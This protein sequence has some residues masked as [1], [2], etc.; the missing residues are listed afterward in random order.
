MII[1][2]W[3]FGDKRQW[4]FIL[5]NSE[6]NKEIKKKSYEMIFKNVDNRPH[7]CMHTKSF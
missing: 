4:Q 7:A 1:L 2:E 6:Q 5:R 3:E